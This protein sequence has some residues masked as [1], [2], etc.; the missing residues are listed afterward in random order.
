MKFTFRNIEFI[1]REVNHENGYVTF[2]YGDYTFKMSE[3]QFSK[4]VITE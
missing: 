2:E 3:E 4:L 1:V